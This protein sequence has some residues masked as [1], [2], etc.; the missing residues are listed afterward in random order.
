[1]AKAGL[2]YANEI[3]KRSRDRL[4]RNNLGLP[5]HVL[6]CTNPALRCSD[7]MQQIEA[8]CRIFRMPMNCGEQALA[9]GESPTSR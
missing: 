1:M 3:V 5:T 8:I 9:R 2:F 6:A 7:G 4:V